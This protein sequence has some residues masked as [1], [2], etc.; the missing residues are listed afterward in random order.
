MVI[1]MD[2]VSGQGGRGGVSFEIYTHSPIHT[3]FHPTTKIVGMWDMDFEIW[4]HIEIHT[5]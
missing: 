3:N 4:T 2:F 5:R 1:R